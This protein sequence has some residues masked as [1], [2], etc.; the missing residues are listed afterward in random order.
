M[1]Q[2]PFVLHASVRLRLLGSSVELTLAQETSQ[3]QKVHKT[4]AEMVL[5]GFLELRHYLHKA[6]SGR[7]VDIMSPGFAESNGCFLLFLFCKVNC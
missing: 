5:S 6:T 3:S 2:K 4:L 1:V 7:W